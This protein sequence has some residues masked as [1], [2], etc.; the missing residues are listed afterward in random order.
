MDKLKY[1][2]NE[3]NSIKASNKYIFEAIK[4]QKQYYNDTAHMLENVTDEQILK[5]CFLSEVLRKAEILEKQK[6][7]KILFDKAIKLETHQN[8]PELNKLHFK[9]RKIDTPKATTITD[10][11]TQIISNTS[12]TCLNGFIYELN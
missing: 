8:A 4:Q 3:L 9:R 1:I 12:L 11:I 5:F 10:A 6:F 2:I 7:Y